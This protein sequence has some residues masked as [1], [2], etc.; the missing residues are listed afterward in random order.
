MTTRS[1]ILSLRGIQKSYGPI[2]VLHGVD[3]D[4]YP[5][6]VVALLGENGAGKSTLSN[7]ISGTVQPSAGEM[8]W[9][10]KS[11]TPADPR[12]AMDEGVGMIHQ[13]LKL[14]PKLSIAENVFVGRYPMKA[15][16][17][18]R[19][20]ME[21]RA[22]SGLHRLGL[23]ISPDRLVEGLSTGK[24]QLIEIAKALTLNARLLILDEPTA[25]LGGEETQLLF[26]QIE[27]LRAEGVGIIYISHRLEEIRQIADRIVVMRDG[28]KVQEFD[29]GDVPIRTIVEAMVGRSLER[30]FPALPT[31][32]DEVTLEVR[33][34]SSAS[35]AFRDINFFV[36]KGEVFGIAGL[37]G[38]GRTELVRAIT[39]ADPISGGEVLLRGKAITPRSPIDAI[40]N[41][42]VLVPED[43][44][45]Q[46]VVLDHSIA[47]NIGYA[48]LGEIASSGW[49]SSR[50]IQQFAEDYIRKFGVKGRGGQNA[51]ELSG[52]NQQK[53]VLA[54]WLAR[55]PQVVV[56]DEPTRGIDVGARSS[57]YDLIMDLARQGVAVIVV[58][59]D[60]EEVLGVSSRIM[61][62]AK[63]K[64]SGI[65]NR[66]DANDVSV[67]EL[68][69]I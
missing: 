4:I 63:G 48:N 9:L 39:G 34:L 11:Y 55:K 59:S 12:A 49:L 7:I 26:Q 19:K 30:M 13:E 2:K 37:M 35:N 8:T 56:L 20:A 32:T 53:V 31:P 57:I 17:I 3:L 18:D 67:M 21:D 25:A 69:T 61:V 6:E 60:L 41:G 44:K 28:A 36:R 47:E 1:P 54:K 16:R 24:Q 38:A 64:Q 14:L 45:L 58:S 29:S 5:G 10:G 46:G 40:R 62:M 27:R 50:R 33:S 15:G 42:I 66:E 65:L 43:R 68:A 22:R 52:G 51:S 23:D